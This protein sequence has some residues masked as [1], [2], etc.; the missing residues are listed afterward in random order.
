M[1]QPEL[2]A[3]FR[4]NTQDLPEI[5]QRWFK[6]PNPV[7][8]HRR[9]QA[10]ESIRDLYGPPLLIGTEVLRPIEDYVSKMNELTKSGREEEAIQYATSRLELATS[11][12][13]AVLLN[14]VRRIIFESRG[15]AQGHLIEQ[16]ELKPLPYG[17]QL[18]AYCALSAG[19]DFMHADLE[20]GQL[21]GWVNK[22]AEYFSLAEM[23]LL[24]RKVIEKA[25]GTEIVA[26]HHGTQGAVPRFS[27]PQDPE[28][29]AMQSRILAKLIPG[30][31]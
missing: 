25:I 12:F 28:I 24:N 13:S 19:A 30:A 7:E 27:H 2:L 11:Q 17:H 5:A 10:G 16:G 26:M 1:P 23:E 21:T 20:L 3:F 22:I 8:I 15:T 31:S 14:F 4:A 9:Y 29:R 6:L 18:K